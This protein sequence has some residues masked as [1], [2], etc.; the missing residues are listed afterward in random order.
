MA[1]K[2]AEQAADQVA[3]TAHEAA[4]RT[5]ETAGNAK[6]RAREY[7]SHADERVREAASQGRQHAD[8]MIGSV[9]GYVRG[10]PLL[11]I[12]IAFIAGVLCLSLTRR[13]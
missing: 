4:D 8:D 11:S 1:I 3:N 6:E 10:N 9:N 12:G 2:T 13:G 5:A 7:A